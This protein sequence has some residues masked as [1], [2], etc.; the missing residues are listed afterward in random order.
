MG[1]K[2]SWKSL[3]N[4]WGD[5]MKRNQQKVSRGFSWFLVVII[6]NLITPVTAWL[7]GG[8]ADWKT[9]AIICVVAG[10]S[11]TIMLI[12]S[13]FGSREKPDVVTPVAPDVVIVEPV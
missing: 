9:Y 13:V 7:S 3:I 6:S 10:I 4:W 11:F 8:F 1:I 2:D 12:E 5:N